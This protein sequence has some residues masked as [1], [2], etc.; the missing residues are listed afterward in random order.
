MELFDG[1]QFA[2]QRERTLQQRLVQA[3]QPA[4][5][6]VAI[7]F[8]E[9]QGSRIYTRLKQE[10]AQR[11]GMTYEVQTFSLS[12]PTEAITAAIVAASVR[13]DVTGI[14]IQ[15]PWRQTWLE[16]QRVAISELAATSRQ[17]NQWWHQLTTA[18][19]PSKDVDGL[20]PETLAAIQAGTW[21]QQG[22]VLPAT[23][24]AVVAIAEAHQLLAD[25]PSVA[26]IGISDL[27][28]RPLAAVWRQ[29]GLAVELLGRAELQQR[30][31]Q[32]Q[33]L[34]DC[35]LIVSATGQAGLIT[36]ELIQPG[37]ALIDVGEPKP[38]VDRASVGDKPRF[39]TPVP[40]GVGPVTVVSLLEN[41]ATLAGYGTV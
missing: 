18:I 37:V 17:F 7:L 14:I 29:Q 3:G 8:T 36:G 19:H 9:D 20:H 40:G 25:R 34:Q 1:L 24:R 32:G 38:D 21:Q 28:G 30:V 4:I 11:V 15:K 2:Q 13:P 41:A 27:L 26:V 22:K 23:C 12:D 31:Q 33:G 6:I 35:G 16:H 10:A 39:L 5:T